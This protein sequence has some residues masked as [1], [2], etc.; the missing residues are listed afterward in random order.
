LW[1]ENKE[2]GELDENEG[3]EKLELVAARRKVTI[4]KLKCVVT[5]VG[6]RLFMKLL[7][8]FPGFSSIP[9]PLPSVAKYSRVPDGAQRFSIPSHAV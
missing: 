5:A 9:L 1:R 3:K 8:P 7:F 4:K 6:H 2:T